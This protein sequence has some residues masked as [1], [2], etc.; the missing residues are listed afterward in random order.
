MR[1]DPGRQMPVVFIFLA[2][3]FAWSWGI[4]G[5]MRAMPSLVPHSRGWG[6][7]YVMALCGPAV[8][9]L[10]ATFIQD[11]LPGTR[12]W[13]KAFSFR[14]TPSVF[15]LL[16]IA[17]PPAAWTLAGLL[18]HGQFS[19]A[20]PISVML[21]IWAKMLVR[22]GPLTEELGWRGFLLPELRRRMNL[23]CTSVVIMGVWGIWHLPLWLVRGLPHQHWSF[24]LFMLFVAP[25][26]LILSWFYVKGNGSV[27]LPIL[28]HTSINFAL[29]FS[30]IEPSLQSAGGFYVLIAILWSVAGGL[31]LA[32]RQLWFGR[33][34]LSEV[35]ASGE[36]RG[37]LLV[38]PFGV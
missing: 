9:A 34:Q 6:L 5:G 17:G 26:T 29:H 28:F 3:T 12:E 15:Y 13:L 14:R 37:E 27:W 11:G 36:R 35:A 30:W 2:V 19:F 24:P 20:Q 8:G 4:W 22:G 32:N 23:F 7:I 31:I 16:A 25:L 18:A 38:K 33:P 10:V 21:V 1:T